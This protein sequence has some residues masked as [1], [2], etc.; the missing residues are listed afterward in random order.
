MLFRLP[1]SPTNATFLSEEERLI[2][3]ERLKA[4][5][6]GYKSNKIDR[7]QILEAFTDTKT[8]MLAVLV[9]A[10]NIPNGGFTTVCSES[11]VS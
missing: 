5:K 7:A 11:L 4:N 2:A 9:L 6:A 10:C 1:D 8:W 3:T